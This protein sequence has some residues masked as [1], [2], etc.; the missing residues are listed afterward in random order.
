MEALGEPGRMVGTF[1]GLHPPL[2]GLL[3]ATMETLVPIPLVFLGFSALCSW[4]AVLFTGLAAQKLA[5]PV[6]GLVA[7]ALMATSPVALHYA[8]ELNNYPLLLALLASMLW[9][10][11]RQHNSTGSYLC[12][13]LVGVAA[14]W[15]HLL[16]GAAAGL[17]AIA[18]A[19]ENRKDGLRHLLI[20]LAASAPILAGAWILTR[21]S[22][23][24]G[25]PPLL[26]EESLRDWKQ[27]LGYTC[28]PA[29]L[30]ALPSMGSH[31]RLFLFQAV[32]AGTIA[33]M[34][35]LGVAA[36]HQFPYWT[37]LVPGSAI[38]AGISTSRFRLLLAPTIT[39][40]LF[41]L[42]EAVED[43]FS[44]LRTIR[45]DMDRARALDLALQEARAGDAIWL[46]SPA[47]EPDDDKR[48]I[49]PVLWRLHPW[50][51]MPMARPFTFD[52]TDYRFGQ[53]RS[54]H[55]LLIYTFTD[56]WPARMD[57]I[58][59]HHLSSHN[60]VWVALYDHAPARDYPERLHR[61]LRPW[62]YTEKWVGT[63]EGL[64][65]DL[66]LLVESSQEETG[67]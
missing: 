45:V 5:G 38:L 3:Y 11:A 16:G 59:Q 43:Q 22:H 17:T 61:V 12:T 60:R 24:F 57:A 44:A 54:Y 10:W 67:R 21:D 37:L 53:P 56:F 27:R 62:K 42:Q 35:L 51:P 47:L 7:T 6:A 31:W 20:L 49:S 26:L 36:P 65:R 13:A 2:Y 9:A 34:I 29:T 32:M 19:L 64:G 25:Q 52:Y 18:T 50:Q 66:L 14:S 1:V 41:Q 23:T 55:D 40:A 15:T 63:D 39:L 4:L 30:L 46:I 33:A 8:A 48:A 58:I 28:I